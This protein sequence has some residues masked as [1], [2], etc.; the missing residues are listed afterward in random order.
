MVHPAAVSADI[1]FRDEHLRHEALGPRAIPKFAVIQKHWAKRLR[2]GSIVQIPASHALDRS[3]F[4]G[5]L[6]PENRVPI[7]FVGT[8][9]RFL[10]FP[11]AVV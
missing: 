3:R 6:F 9:N 10:A 5:G 8:A 2:R 11:P 4:L 1:M 7:F